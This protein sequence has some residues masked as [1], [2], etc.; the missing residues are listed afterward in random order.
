MG[1][2]IPND[3]PTGKKADIRAQVDLMK[4]VSFC[5]TVQVGLECAG[6]TSAASML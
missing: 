1:R 5:G 4:E 6:E 2:L 3:L